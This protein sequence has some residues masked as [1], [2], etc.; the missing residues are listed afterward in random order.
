MDERQ[1]KYGEESEKPNIHVIGI[2]KG[3]EKEIK[4]EACLMT[5]DQESYKRYYI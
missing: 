5:K 3:N 4:V 1:R 2:S